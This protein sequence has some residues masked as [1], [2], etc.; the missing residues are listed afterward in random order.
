MAYARK[1]KYTKKTKKSTKRSASKTTTKTIKSIVKKEINK[2]AESKHLNMD[3]ILYPWDNTIVDDT[4]TN[5]FNSIDL[6]SNFNMAQGIT[7]GTRIGNSIDVTKCILNMNIVPAPSLEGPFIVSIYVGYLKA[8][9]SAIPSGGTLDSS[10][11]QD[12]ANSTGLDET[13]L[14]LL[15]NVNKDSWHIS[16]SFRFKLGTSGST[17]GV[18]GQI[19]NN[20]FPAY[21]NKKLSI[22]ALLG[23]M[24][25]NDS[26]ETPSKD[27]YMWCHATDI[28]GRVVDGVD[29][30]QIN[31]YLDVEYKD[32]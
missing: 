26:S 16:N 6:T 5:M 28:R 32:F 25:Y 8:F 9:R 22:K 17:T 29:L 3:P 10:F 24:T 12:G 11:L 27:L 2:K 21:V 23:K 14:S 18:N 7:D 15:R 20:D 31:Y 19:F 13:T 1:R 4:N 30:P